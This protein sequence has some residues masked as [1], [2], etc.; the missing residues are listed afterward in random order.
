MRSVRRR[1]T[2]GA[3]VKAGKK[4][5]ASAAVPPA[6]NSEA[7]RSCLDQLAKTRI[8]VISARRELEQL[9]A[10][11]PI[12]WDVEIESAFGLPDRAPGLLEETGVALNM[13]DALLGVLAAKGVD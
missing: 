13:A 10:W 3:P 9:R 11:I 2:A 7:V 5:G 6:L 4:K 8:A 1:A 12:L